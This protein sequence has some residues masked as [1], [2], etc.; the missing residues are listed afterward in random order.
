MSLAL[1]CDN[2]KRYNYLKNAINK[3]ALKK[4]LSDPESKKEILNILKKVR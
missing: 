1:E 4:A 2:M 3:K